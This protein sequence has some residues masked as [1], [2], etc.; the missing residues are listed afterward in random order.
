MKKI[1]PMEV[2]RYNF[3]T[4]IKQPKLNFYCQNYAFESKNIDTSYAI[5]I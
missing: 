5:Y 2:V 1:F 4:N 3:D